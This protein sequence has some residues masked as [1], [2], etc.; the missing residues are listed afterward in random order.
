[1]TNIKYPIRNNGREKHSI[2]SK[3][4]YGKNYFQKTESFNFSLDELRSV[5]EP[6]K[7][8]LLAEKGEFEEILD[9]DIKFDIKFIYKCCNIVNGIKQESKK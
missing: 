9:K 2:F 5:F 4:P 1:M 8:N 6:Y 3:N 7:D